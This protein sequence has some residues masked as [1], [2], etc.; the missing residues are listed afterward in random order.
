MH[1]AMCW[2]ASFSMVTTIRLPRI[3]IGSYC[4]LGGEMIAPKHKIQV[5]ISSTC[6]DTPERQKYNYVREALKALIES[7]GFADV[8][9][10]E[11]EGASTATAEEHF[12]YHLETCDV[13]L[14]LIDNKD[15]VTTGVQKEIDAVKKRGIKSFYY[16]CDQFSDKKTPLQK[17]L[18]GDK[19]AKSVTIHDFKSLIKDGVTD[20][21]NDLAMVYKLYCKGHIVATKEQSESDAKTVDISTI[22]L[23]P[24]SDSLV[25]KDMLANIDCCVN[26]FTKLILTNSFDEIART[27]SIDKTCAAFLPVIFE[28]SSI[29]KNIIH[30]F[31]SEIEVHQNPQHFAVTKKRFEAIEEYYSGNLESCI[32]KLKEALQLAKDNNLPMWLIQDVLLD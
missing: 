27:N 13:C 32:D 31:L 15:G 2:H 11:S 19:H 25:P 21:I 22:E 1:T 14:F 16:F 9:V 8:Y 12:M 28:R 26:Y 23:V 20:L 24:H 10:F 6:G 3:I 30:S 5:F 17:S 18:Q 29:N 4:V 7:T